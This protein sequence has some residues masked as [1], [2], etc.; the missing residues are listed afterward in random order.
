MR[1]LLP[2][3]L[4]LTACHPYGVTSPSG[5]KEALLLSE[6]DR[7]ATLMGVKVRGE[8]SDRQPQ[9]F[10]SAGV[11]AA[12]WYEGGVAYY[13]RPEIERHMSIEPEAGKETCTNVA[14]HETCH[15]LHRN[16]DLAHWSCMNQWATP[17]YPHP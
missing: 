8:I 11:T 14:A 6:T 15:A 9:S 16:H 13:Y 1:Y 12:G 3:V 4:L 17:T 2:L 10:I 7:F 5:E